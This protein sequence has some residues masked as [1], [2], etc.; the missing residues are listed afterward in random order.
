MKKLIVETAI[1]DQWAIPQSRRNPPKS[2]YL[3]LLE[4]VPAPGEA[5]QITFETL[6]Q[7]KTFGTMMSRARRL[8][9]TLVQSAR[10]GNVMFLWLDAYNTSYQVQAHPEYWDIPADLR[11]GSG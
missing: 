9:K 7:A 3:A 11:Y 1:I 6:R 4:G 2:Q 8:A 10:Q 5:L